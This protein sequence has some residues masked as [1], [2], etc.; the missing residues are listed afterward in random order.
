MPD[1]GVLSLND[2]AANA[3]MI[4]SLDRRVPLIADADTGF[5]GLVPFLQWL[6]IDGLAY[7]E[8][9]L[10]KWLPSIS[11]SN[12]CRYRSFSRQFSKKSVINI[13]LEHPQRSRKFMSLLCRLCD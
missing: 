11:L 6:I 4:A 13:G 3:G 7:L 9:V 2:M 5:G 1:L 10:R 8:D 12:R